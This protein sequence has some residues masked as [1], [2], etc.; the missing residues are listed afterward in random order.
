[1]ATNVA[2]AQDAA[3][4]APAAATPAPATTQPGVTLVNLHLKQTVAED[5]FLAVGKIGGVKFSPNGNVWDQDASQVPNDIDFTD[6]PFWP[7]VQEM[8]AM[9]HVTLS[10]NFNSGRHF[11]VNAAPL[12]G[13]NQTWQSFPHYVT[14]GFLVE[15]TGFNLNMNYNN[16]TF[17]NCNVQLR[18][19]VDPA[20]RVLT[21][22]GAGRV[23]EAVDDAGHSMVMNQ[24]NGGG[25]FSGPN[26]RTLVYDCS[27]PLKYP[28]PA[29]G[30]KIAH[31]KCTVQ[32][33]AG[34]KM[35]TL[36]ID[37]PMKA[38][39][40]SKQFG[41]TKVTFRSLKHNGGNYELKAT[42]A[43]TDD[44]GNGGNNDWQMLQNSAQLLDSEGNPY[45]YGGGGGGSSRG[46][47]Y[48]Y[49]I[50]YNTGGG[51][52]DAPK[53]DPAKWTIELPVD[54]HIMRVPV[55]FSDLPLP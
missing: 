30:K 33:R 47:V 19:Y 37:D 11:M 39:Q 10:N 51:G 8:C 9:W 38:S 22:N 6:K 50:Y 17:S 16:P 32:L 21:F 48:N 13:P 25:F 44:D 49:S 43:R 24:G 36:T 46:G 7:A 12:T 1:M 23:Q 15:A 41:D 40:T 27:V 4:A 3:P 55:E 28:S 18:V 54:S 42:I 34:D 31:L 45:Q 29:A 5:A 2:T 52:E 26:Q 53:G 35:E 20:L 14:E